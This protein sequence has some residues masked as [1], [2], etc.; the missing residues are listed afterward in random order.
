MRSAEA[1]GDMGEVFVGQRSCCHL[2]AKLVD[3]VNDGVAEA[4][5]DLLCL[6]QLLPQLVELPAKP[7]LHRLGRDLKACGDFLEGKAELS[8]VSQSPRPTLL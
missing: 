6:G 7:S 3:H 5:L 8:G 2:G 1:E 4:A